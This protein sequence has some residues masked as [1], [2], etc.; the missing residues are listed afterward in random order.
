MAQEYIRADN[1]YKIITVGYK[2]LPVILKFKFNKKLGRAEF[3]KHDVIAVSSSVIPAKAGI[4][5]T[6]F[7]FKSRR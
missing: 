4:Q 1:E 7:R 6:R 5:I 3:S 2:V